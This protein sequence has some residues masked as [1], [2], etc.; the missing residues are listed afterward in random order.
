[1]KFINTGYEPN[2]PSID[3]CSIKPIEIWNYS[4]LP[5]IQTSEHE[6]IKPLINIEYSWFND[7]VCL[8]LQ[9]ILTGQCENKCIDGHYKTLNEIL[10]EYISNFY[11]IDDKNTIDYIISKYSIESNWEYASE[12]NVEDYVYDITLTLK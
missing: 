7:N 10:K 1:M 2:Y 6:S 9:P 12:T 11:N 4:S 5:E 3:Y 8:P